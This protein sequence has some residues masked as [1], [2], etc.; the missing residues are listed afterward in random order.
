MVQY[1]LKRGTVETNKDGE[2]VGVSRPYIHLL[3]ED[4]TDVVRRKEARG[5]RRLGEEP[6]HSE[7][8]LPGVQK[9]ERTFRHYDS[10]L[11]RKLK[12]T[13]R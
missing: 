6:S 9:E 7:A 5:I 13:G 2:I 1:R 4:I 8:R 12:P 11:L 10:N 3:G